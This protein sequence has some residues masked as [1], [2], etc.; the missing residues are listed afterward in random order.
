MEE[1]VKTCMNDTGTGS[2]IDTKLTR[3]RSGFG[4]EIARQYFIAQRNL[5]GARTPIGRRW[6]NLVEQS[7]SYARATDPEQIWHLQC[8]IALSVMEIRGL[9]RG[10]PRRLLSKPQLLLAFSTGT[11]H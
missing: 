7:E 2:Q 1:R 6:S 3:G 5:E 4:L 9:K 11:F 10:R 8:S